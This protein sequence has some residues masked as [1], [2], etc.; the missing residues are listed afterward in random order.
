MKV[1]RRIAAVAGVET[2]AP[3]ATTVFLVTL[4]LG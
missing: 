4:V 3:G 1:L 2:V